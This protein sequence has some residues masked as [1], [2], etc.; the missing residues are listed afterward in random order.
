MNHILGKWLVEVVI[1]V[2]HDSISKI[3]IVFSFYLF[4]FYI[5]KRILAASSEELPDATGILQLNDAFQKERSRAMFC[6]EFYKNDI[7]ILENFL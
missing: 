2:Q 7:F 4:V 3:Y 1:A 5:I 6:A